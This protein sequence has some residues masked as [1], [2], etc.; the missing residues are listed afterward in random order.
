MGKVIRSLSRTKQKV[1]GGDDTE[2]LL[3][4][5]CCV[6]CP[7]HSFNP[8]QQPYGVGSELLSKWPWSHTW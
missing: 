1:A 2:H 6:L 3:H 5:P 8:S 7:H 4:T